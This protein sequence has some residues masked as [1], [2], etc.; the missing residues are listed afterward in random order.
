VPLTVLFIYLFIC[1]Q[2][3]CIEKQ[4]PTNNA[5]DIGVLPPPPTVT[6]NYIRGGKSFL[7]SRFLSPQF[8]S[9][10]L[11]VCLAGGHGPILTFD[12][13]SPFPCVVASAARAPVSSTA[14]PRRAQASSADVAPRARVSS[15]VVALPGTGELSRCGPVSTHQLPNRGLVRA[16]TS[17]RAVA[18]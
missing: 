16:C 9:F 17:S 1:A 3:F 11:R 10:P 8:G 2:C 4:V 5:N 13:R 15:P 7:L 14:G 6:Q 18:M 12:R